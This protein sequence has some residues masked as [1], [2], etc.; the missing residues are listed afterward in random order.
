[1]TALE[2][3]LKTAPEDA[4]DWA[5]AMGQLARAYML[6][7]RDEEAVTHADRALAAIGSRRVPQLT[8]DILATRGAALLTRPDE[9]EA[10]LRGAIALAERSGHLPTIM[11]TR[12]NLLSVQ[13]GYISTSEAAPF[14]A[15][16]AD[17][18]RRGG[19]A[20]FLAQMLLQLADRYFEAGTWSDM[21]APLEELAGMDLDS[22]RRAWYA[23]TIGV[24]Q[25]FRGDRA[26]AERALATIEKQVAGVDTFWAD[27]VVVVIAMFRFGMGDVQLAAD[28][29]M[30]AALPSTDYF[31]FL[32]AVNAVG[33]LEPARAR[34]LLASAAERTPTS[35]M[36]AA[37]AQIEAVVA[38][39][40]GRWDDARA[41]Y[42]SALQGFDAL[43]MGLWRAMAGLQ[44]D[45]YLGQQFADARQ[46]GVEA[47]AMFAANDAESFVERYRVA[48]RG[49][50]APAADN[51]SAAT[52]ATSEVPVS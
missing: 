13:S 47:E 34:E 48:F 31:P 42:R 4:P 41:A 3:A 5:A 46:A 16:S 49:I 45:A 24:V 40:D 6:M 17:V 35:A 33:G 8:A 38:I 20:H 52:R 37:I 25:A 36:V 27:N 32:T 7:G 9:A 50:P 18:A 51:A 15:E 26:E 30:P 10:S 23:S 43:G 29:A 11:R 39:A 1:M 19:D 14:L 22:W 12:N 21:S 44:F 28:I 2:G